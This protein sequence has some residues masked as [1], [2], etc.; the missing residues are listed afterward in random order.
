MGVCSFSK[1]GVL[2]HDIS[3]PDVFPR[4]A[5]RKVLK[6]DLPAKNQS[7]MTLLPA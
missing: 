3:I 4:D 2:G 1:L 7:V 5:Q 6:L